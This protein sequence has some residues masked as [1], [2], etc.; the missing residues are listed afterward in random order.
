MLILCAAIVASD[1]DLMIGGGDSCQG[2]SGG[3]L[4]RLV[5]RF[6]L[7]GFL[8]KYM[9]I[10]SFWVGLGLCQSIQSKALI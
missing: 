7:K 9:I 5:N 6:L 10:H 3:P 4:V 2:D 8:G 1:L